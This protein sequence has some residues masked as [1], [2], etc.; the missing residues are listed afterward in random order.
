MLTSMWTFSLI[1]LGIGYNRVSGHAAPQK[2][3]GFRSQLT[4]YALG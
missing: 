1:G 4:R 3:E 2:E